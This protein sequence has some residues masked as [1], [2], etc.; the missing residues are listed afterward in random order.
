[1][2]IVLVYPFSMLS[3]CAPILNTLILVFLHTDFLFPLIS[4]I[5]QHIQQGFF[6][7]FVAILLF[8]KPYHLHALSKKKISKLNIKTR[9]NPITLKLDTQSIERLTIC[10]C[11]FA[12]FNS[13]IE[14]FT[15]WTKS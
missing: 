6:V 1:M 9:T 2:T 13:D 5:K 14:K 11:N 4:I 12:I 7:N 15:P 3:N 8:K 10:L